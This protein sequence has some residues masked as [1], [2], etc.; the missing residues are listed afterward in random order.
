[1]FSGIKFDQSN[2]QIVKMINEAIIEQLNDILKRAVSG[3][4]KDVQKVLRRYLLN[5]HTFKAIIHGDILKGELGIEYPDGKIGQIID[6]WVGGVVVEHRPLKLFTQWYQNGLSIKMVQLDF[7]DVLLLDG[8]EQPTDRGQILPWLEWLLL[9]GG[10]YLIREYRFQ[11]GNYAASRTGLGIM[12]QS[13][14]SWNIP[15]EFQGVRDDN[16]IT[17]MLYS[18][19]FIS[20]IDEVVQD[21]ILGV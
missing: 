5:N 10:E 13:D 14:R 16:F 18:E 20:A 3:V 12:V 6:K 21:R 4:K 17:Q 2:K 9:R 11:A 15:E 8:A 1:M 19:D 7:E